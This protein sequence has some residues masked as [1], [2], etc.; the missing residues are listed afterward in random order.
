M[1]L[2]GGRA[3]VARITLARPDKGNAITFDVPRE[4]AACVEQANLDPAVHVHAL[5]GNGKGFCGGYDLGMCAEG[6][7]KT[8]GTAGDEPRRSPLDMRR[9]RAQP[10]PGRRPGTRSSTSR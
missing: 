2:R 10:R 5:A 8:R 4:L 6:I 7:G 9:Q 3:G 1:P